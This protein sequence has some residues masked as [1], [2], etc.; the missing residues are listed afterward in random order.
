MAGDYDDSIFT[1]GIFGDDV[2]NRKFALRSVSGE[3]VAFD[4]IAFQMS[5]DVLFKFLV[6]RAPD[7]A[8]AERDD[9]LDVLEG[10]GGV[11]GWG[12]R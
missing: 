6:A 9:F 11:D 1:A 4:L 10:T 8:R 7:R 5:E 2:A 12:G 3:A